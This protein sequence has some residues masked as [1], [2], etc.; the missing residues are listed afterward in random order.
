M[1]PNLRS[2]TSHARSVRH[3]PGPLSAKYRALYQ[4]YEELVAWQRRS[5]RRASNVARMASWAMQASATGWAMVRAN[6]LYFTNPAFRALAQAVPSG[7][8]W[9]TAVAR[10]GRPPR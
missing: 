10:N 7:A 9:Q 1:A 5:E 6:D 3:R 4:R 8:G 2:A